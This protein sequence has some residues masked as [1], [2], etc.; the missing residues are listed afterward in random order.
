MGRRPPVGAVPF[1]GLGVAAHR[2]P[3]P[4]RV[5]A[6]AVAG[7]RAKTERRRWVGRCL[8]VHPVGPATLSSR[9]GHHLGRLV[10][11][12]AGDAVVL[13]DGAGAEMAATVVEVACAL[14]RSS[15][16]D[17]LF[18]HGTEAGVHSFRPIL[19]ERTRRQTGQR[20]HWEQILIAACAQ[21]D[22]SVL[23]PTTRVNRIEPS[24]VRAAKASSPAVLL[25]TTEVV[26]E[27]S[28][29]DR[30]VWLLVVN[31]TE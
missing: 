29:I 15:R 7:E 12:K 14:P 19:T 2:T 5:V 6:V 16:A 22:R 30:S 8:H 13:F 9:L 20:R 25:S 10:R 1:E 21:C 28:H 27:A 11:T 17:R 24:S 23:V 18:E 3:D 31:P 4:A 26:P